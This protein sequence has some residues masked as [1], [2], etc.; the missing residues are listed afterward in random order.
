MKIMG[1]EKLAKQLR[2]VPDS[3]RVHVV[4]AIKRNVEQGAKVDVFAGADTKHVAELVRQGLARPPVIFAEN[5]PVLLVGSDAWNEVKS[6]AELVNARR[7]VLGTTEGATL[8]VRVGTPWD[9]RQRFDL[10]AFDVAAKKFLAA[11]APIV[12]EGA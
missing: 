6:F 2:Q 11:T 9:W 4:K 12:G 1:A 7:I 8:R 3:A 5:E 10:K